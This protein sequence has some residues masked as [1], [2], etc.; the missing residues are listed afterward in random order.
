MGMRF[1]TCYVECIH[2]AIALKTVAS[3]LAKYK[4]DLTAV[5]EVRWD[6]GGS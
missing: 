6:K 3:I 1:G 4:F 2:R 5:Q